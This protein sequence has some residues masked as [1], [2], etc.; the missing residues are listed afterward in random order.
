[1]AHLA[2]QEESTPLRAGRSWVPVHTHRLRV[3]EARRSLRVREV[4][5]LG[6]LR[7][8]STR[9]GRQRLVG[10]TRVALEATRRVLRGQDPALRVGPSEREVLEAS[11]RRRGQE[12]GRNH[13][14]RRHLDRREG[15]AAVEVQRVRSFR[16]G[17]RGS[18]VAT[19]V[20]WLLGLVRWGVSLPRLL[21]LGGCC[22]WRGA[23]G[24]PGPPSLRGVW[25]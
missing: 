7:V 8:D 14:G 2:L 18:S 25:P 22:R 5:S 20:E 4:Q 17:R 12:R 9:W 21:R 1:V 10:P 3:R 6:V 11:T 13:R 16:E 19:W 24:G 15:V 23:C